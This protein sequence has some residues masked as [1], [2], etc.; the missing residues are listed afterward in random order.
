MSADQH[1]AHA[2]APETLVRLTNLGVEATSDSV[3]VIVYSTGPARVGIG[4]LEMKPLTDTLR[5]SMLPAITL[6]VTKADV[7]VR[8]LSPGRLRLGGEVTNGRAIRFTA[9]GR[10]VLVLKGGVGVET[11]TDP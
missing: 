5:L 2:R 11:I 4:Q 8:L 10:H 7:H 6:D 3:Q 1:A 9:T